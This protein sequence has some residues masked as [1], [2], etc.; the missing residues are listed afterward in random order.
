LNE[1]IQARDHRPKALLSDFSWVFALHA[2]AF[3]PFFDF[4]L[5]LCRGVS[6]GQ[7]RPCC[8]SLAVDSV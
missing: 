1:Q 5:N 8:G 3:P 7:Y 2:L 6:V 4:R